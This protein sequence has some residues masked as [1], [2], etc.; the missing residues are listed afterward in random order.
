MCSGSYTYGYANRLRRMFLGS[1]VVKADGQPALAGWTICQVDSYGKLI[2]FEVM[3]DGET[4]IALLTLGNSEVIETSHGSLAVTRTRV[5]TTDEL[6]CYMAPLGP[7]VLS[8]PLTMA[9]LRNYRLNHPNAQIG[10]QLL[11]QTFVAGTT[12]ELRAEILHSAGL[13]PFVRFGAMAED[14]LIRLHTSIVSLFKRVREP[15]VHRQTRVHSGEVRSGV[16]GGQ[17]VYYMQ[18]D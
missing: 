6:L 3:K 14:E 18:S 10:T 9:Y 4:S 16:L 11:K 8:I 7:D 17:K 1:M 5:I 12:N 15:L 13:S 2:W